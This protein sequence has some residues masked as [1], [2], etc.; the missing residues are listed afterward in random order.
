MNTTTIN[1]FPLSTPDKDPT[2]FYYKYCVIVPLDFAGVLANGTVLYGFIKVKSYRMASRI[3][4]LL[5]CL[6][7]LNLLWSLCL[8]LE[9]I[10]VLFHNSETYIRF[11]NAAACVW[12]QTTT[13]INVALAMERCFHVNG[14][15][16]AVA[17]SRKLL[18]IGQWVSYS[19]GLGFVLWMN[20]AIP[21][22][23]LSFF[24]GA[25]FV[26]PLVL[27]GTLVIVGFYAKT[28][29]FAQKQ[30]RDIASYKGERYV[31]A[32][33][34]K[35]L[36][37]SMIMMSSI[38]LFY[39]PQVILFYWAARDERSKEVMNAAINTIAG[40]DP[41]LV[42]LLVLYFVPEVCLFLKERVFGMDGGRSKPNDSD[43][44]DTCS[45]EIENETGIH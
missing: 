45:T 39:F 25:Y 28:Y 26:P 24:T 44:V 43:S 10:A 22:E 2:L 18:L 35:I 31:K 23:E 19:A 30:V 11:T 42:A 9:T 14:C 16:E 13:W 40:L 27:I 3:D 34:R 32:V 17:G 38:Y 36:M 6:C 37:N 12:M 8:A 20:L 4:R 1:P 15:E 41:I 21:L 29:A 33:L 7:M 5:S